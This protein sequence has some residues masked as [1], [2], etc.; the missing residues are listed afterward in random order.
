MFPPEIKDS[1]NYQLT[2][3]A[4]KPKPETEK[5][6][7]VVLLNNLELDQ[8]R[9]Q[10]SLYQLVEELEKLRPAIVVVFGSFVSKA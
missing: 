9:V 10:E 2:D 6:D 3:S 4:M 8:M 7:I 5:N 1:Y